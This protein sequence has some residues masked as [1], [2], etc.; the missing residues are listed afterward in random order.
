[1]ALELVFF[2]LSTALAVCALWTVAAL[3]HLA[4][5]SNADS[6]ERVAFWLVVAPVAA[7][8]FVL[9]FFAGWAAQEP[10]PSD[11]WLKVGLWCL[12]A[13]TVLASARAALRAIR[14]LRIPP[15]L[16][17]GTVGL[18]SPRIVVSPDFEAAT[19]EAGLRAALAHEAAHRRHRDPL[20]IWLVALATDL[21]WPLPGARARFD[22][23]LVALE[24]ERDEEALAAGA[25]RGAL[26]GAILAAAK[27]AGRGARGAA[28]ASAGAEPGVAVRVRRLLRGER[29]APR[30]TSRRWSV[31]FLCTG[32]LAMAWL[33][34]GWGDALLAVL[35]GIGR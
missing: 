21:Q 35:P 26:A 12:S 24:V 8:G 13:L 30:P 28:V 3:S 10:D 25:D 9:A 22:S 17:I 11:E 23:W 29:S 1:M 16:P 5:R 18:L 32:A 19:D 14:A 2:G 31:V 27:L 20:R 4:R 6:S 33:G 34:H 7:A 15:G